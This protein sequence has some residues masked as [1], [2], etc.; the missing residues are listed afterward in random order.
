MIKDELR[1]DRLI[2]IAEIIL[3]IAEQEDDSKQLE[4]LRALAISL[5][6][7]LYTSDDKLN[8]NIGFNL[9]EYVYLRQGLNKTPDSIDDATLAD[10][11]QSIRDS[12]G[13]KE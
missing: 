5:A 7:L 2:D 13:P 8:H 3:D 1:D 11:A 4:L 9:Q 6:K 12:I 10:W